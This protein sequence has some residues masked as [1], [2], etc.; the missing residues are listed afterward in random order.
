MTERA[1]ELAVDLYVA[2]GL[3]AAE[4]AAKKSEEPEPEH[5]TPEGP[6][7]ADPPFEELEEDQPEPEIE[8]APEPPP[9]LSFDLARPW[10]R[11]EQNQALRR[12]SSSGRP[13]WRQTR[14]TIPVALNDPR[15]R[16]VPDAAGLVERPPDL[17]V[18]VHPRSL[19]RQGFSHKD[20]VGIFLVVRKQTTVFKPELLV[21]GA[22][23]R[24]GRV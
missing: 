24:E 15:R 16:L 20:T 3:D 22:R 18:A 19:L 1:K 13:Q 21:Q 4:Q 2:E 8:P 9:G 11:P 6:V 10:Q 14:M 7:H 17:L 12:R 23:R 5:G